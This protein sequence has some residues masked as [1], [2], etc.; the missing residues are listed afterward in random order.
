MLKK[1]ALEI[2]FIYPIKI[3]CFQRGKVVMIKYTSYFLAR[4]HSYIYYR[5]IHFSRF[6]FSV[7]LDA[8]AHLYERVSMLVHCRFAVAVGSFAV[9][10]QKVRK[11]ENF[12]FR[13]G[14]SLLTFAA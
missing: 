10:H 13:D 6:L 1:K 9:L 7:V 11:R 5:F 3:L 12:E 4:Y 14:L 8:S 2:L